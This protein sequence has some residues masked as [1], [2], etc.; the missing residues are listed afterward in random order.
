MKVG[1]ATVDW[2]KNVRDEQ[3]DMPAMGGSNWIRFGQYLPY[4]QQITPLRGSPSR[5]PKQIFGV[6]TECG[7][8]IDSYDDTDE[9]YDFDIPVIFIQY[10]MDRGIGEQIALARSNGQI[11]IQDIDDDFLGDPVEQRLLAH[12]PVEE[13]GVEHQLLR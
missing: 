12:A 9:R 11:I 2:S 5:T 3:L 13:P 6:D 4:M 7:W 10:I 8:N 1:F